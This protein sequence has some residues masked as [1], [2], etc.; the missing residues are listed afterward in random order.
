MNVLLVAIACAVG[1]AGVM[2][3]VRGAVG[4]TTP[5]SAVV[6]E[7]HR[8]RTPTATR[9][10]RERL[11]EQ[12]AGRRT[13]RLE[14]DLAVCERTPARYVQDRLVW[15]LLLAAPGSGLT[16]LWAV[17]A[18]SWASP[19]VGVVAI[20]AGA[21]GGWWWARADLASDAERHRRTFRHALAAYL[22]LV[23]ILLSGGAGVETAMFDAVAAGTGAPFRHL[24]SALS[25]AQARREAP[26]RT[27]GELGRR[28]GIDELEELEASMTLAGGGA[29]VRDSLTAKAAGIRMKDLA[30]LESEAQ[31][32][33]ET[34]VLPVALMFAGFL[35]LIGYPALAALST[36]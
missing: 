30:G 33:S 20:L 14:R 18:V 5:L 7:L 2:L 6:A 8:P 11:V 3:I 34:M 4:V 12:L 25:A 17:A 21:L 9:S 35:V 28:L 31:A 23:T 10:R 32:R 19:T 13:T 36:P 16:L 15:A 26:W 24:R 29:Q 27:L 1:A 22:E